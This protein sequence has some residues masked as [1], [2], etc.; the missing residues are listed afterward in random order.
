MNARRLRLWLGLVLV[1][2]ASG[3]TPGVTPHEAH[4]QSGRRLLRR[5]AAVGLPTPVPATAPATSA[6]KPAPTVLEKKPTRAPTPMLAFTPAAADQTTAAFTADWYA[7]YPQAWRPAQPPTDWWRAADAATLSSWLERPVSQAG[8]GAAELGAVKTT[9]AEEVGADGLRSVLVLPAG[10]D[11]R[12]NDTDWLPLG[13]FAVMLPGGSEPHNYQQL[14][15]DREGTI[16]G[17]FYDEISDTVQP[18]AGTIDRNTRKVSWTVGANGS[19][20]TA[21]L[22][23]FATAPRNVRV[24][25]AGKARDMELVP[26]AKP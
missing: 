25:S 2:A 16:K 17:N 23:A 10:H 8:T 11:H 9:G 6:A 18:I 20:F 4:A 15:A 12:V 24:V 5:R 7:R 14:A 13:V 21:A 3:L 26:V 19:R 1:A 22:D